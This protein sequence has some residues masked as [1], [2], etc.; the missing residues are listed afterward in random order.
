MEVLLWLENL[1]LWLSQIDNYAWKYGTVGRG[2][3]AERDI[4]HALVQKTKT[5]RT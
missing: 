3:L 2:W 1:W 5:P 4:I